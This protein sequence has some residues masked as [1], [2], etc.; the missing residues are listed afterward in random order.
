MS[1]AIRLT[2]VAQAAGVSPAYLT[3]VFTRVEGTPVHRYL[4]RLR[5][6]RALVDVPHTNDLTRLA[7]DLG[8]SHHSHLTAAFRRAFG[9]TPSRFRKAVRHERHAIWRA[10][11]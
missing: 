2:D 9:C 5:L 4:L 11:S 1:S 3:T 10:A 7:Y 8:F 6:A